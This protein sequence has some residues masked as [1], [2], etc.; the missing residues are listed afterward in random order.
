M[1]MAPAPW[2]PALTLAI[3]EA[4]G[5]ALLDLLVILA[6]AAGVTIVLSRF[7]VSAAPGY[8]IAGVLAGPHALGLVSGT[9]HVEMIA[10][11]ALL[12]L[13]FHIGMHLDLAEMRGSMRAIFT[14]GLGTTLV[15]AVL[16]T[17]AAMLFG[18]SVAAAATVGMALSL[19]STA[20][21]L[22][23]LAQRREL[24]S[25]Y[26]RVCF[27]VLLVQDLVVIG[28]LAVLPALAAWAEVSGGDAAALAGGAP[29]L[30][31]Q[32]WEAGLRVAAVALVL[33]IGRRLLPKLMLG[34]AK[35]AAPEVLLV[36]SAALALAAGLGAAAVGLSPELGAFVAGF[37]L[38]STAVR[39][40]LAGQLA[41]VRDLF[42]AVFFTAVGLKVDIVA[43]LSLWWVVLLAVGTLLI[44][45]TLVIGLGVWLAGARGGVALS[46]GVSLAQAGEFSLVVLGSAYG[47]GLVQSPV[48]DKV[49]AAVIIGLILTPGLMTV[50]RWAG[51]GFASG[52]PTNP[53]SK[54]GAML[55][56]GGSG[57]ASPADDRPLVIVVG[58]GPVGR[59]VAE[60][61]ERRGGRVTIVELNPETVR[62]QR[63]LGRSA[64]FGDSSNPDVLE[65]AGIE[66]AAA[67]VVTIPDE[68]AMMRTTRTARRTRPDLCIAV[69][70]AIMSRAMLAM[71]SGANHVTV[72][73]I[74]T[75]E[76]MAS[77]VF[78]MLEARSIV[79]AD[80]GRDDAGKIMPEAA[81]RG[82]S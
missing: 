43:A 73:E 64:I 22:K 28:F 57:D 34:A 2:I 12:F 68:D 71:E 13:M 8:L 5:A 55:D 20:V 41:P 65:A 40:Q 24:H 9:E 19:S 58:Y 74:A 82:A 52:W 35:S 16:G 56:E 31:G 59:A 11:L 69:R 4:P 80:D 3:A 63:R 44:V 42:L 77:A 76:A 6:C 66:R 18:L 67:L 1:G 17:G 72:E 61:I 14:V 32:L 70:S 36:L 81:D 7:R 62:R 30:V 48:E 53:W 51:S 50:G 78:K 15:S 46:V 75:A 27:G 39:H 60:R 38:A 47:L 37:L 45:K 54:R 49:V 21:V 10:E 25:V 26:G 29:L 33:V 23:L 79:P